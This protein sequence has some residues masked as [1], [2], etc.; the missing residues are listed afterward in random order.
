M[1]SHNPTRAEQILAHALRHTTPCQSHEGVPCAIVPATPFVHRVVPIRSILF[2]DWLIDTF[3]REHEIF[4]SALAL[5]QSIK[6]F[7]AKARHSEFPRQSLA[8]RISHQ[9]D[10][11]NP[12]AILLD[13]SNPDGEAVHITQ[14]GWRLTTTHQPFR[15]THSQQP[16]PPP[17]TNHQPPATLP[18]AAI[19]WLLSSLRPTGPYPILV[20]K[21][22]AASGKTFL[23]RK[24]RNLIDPAP[25]AFSPLPRTERDLMRHAWNNYV[26]AFDHVTRLPAKV[27]TALCRLSSGALFDFDSIP[28]R[29]Q[30]PIILTVP[31]DDH[32]LRHIANHAITIN[33]PPIKPAQRRTE[34]DLLQE[35][36]AQ[37][38]A[39]L[40]SLCTAVSRAMGNVN[41]VASQWAVA[42]APALGIS[43]H[44]MH[45]TLTPDPLAREV[46]AFA[47]EKQYWEGTA[48][49]LLEALRAA[50]VP[51]L[52]AIPAHLT[53]RL[54]QAP[55]TTLGVTLDTR[56]AHAGNRRLTLATHFVA[57]RSQC[58]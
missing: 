47:R 20:L 6:S 34:R 15:P 46:A 55:L 40:G 33:L 58:A 37:R 29:L 25:C 23:A 17:I 52:P 36:E 30:R 24:V 42:A 21:G 13:L 28:I 12:T 27:A 39:L 9:G 56:K 31:D 38:P 50:R 4:P 41:A 48:T 49:E 11:L 18:P 1:K 16:L 5:R 53:R 2:R 7:E 54:H 26:V 32:V 22:P 3:L 8:L 35:F 10:P 44:T 51:D 45:A 43:E 57:S 19:A 14:E